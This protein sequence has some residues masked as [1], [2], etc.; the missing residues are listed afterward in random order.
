MQDEK[1]LQLVN[2]Y[3]N[4]LPERIRSYLNQRHLPNE[5]I[6]KFCLIGSCYCIDQPQSRC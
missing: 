3:H 1:M 6:N 4:A 5:I 2:G